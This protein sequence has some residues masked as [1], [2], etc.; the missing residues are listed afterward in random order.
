MAMD[1]FT[2]P[3]TSCDCERA[4]SSAR[5][6][7]T[8]D[9]NSLSASTIE[10]CQ[11]QKNWLRRKAVF[12]HLTQLTAFLKGEDEGPAITGNTI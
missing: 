10:A 2:I 11:L 3:A 12:S 9:R 8:C 6:T 7:I 4:F 5:R 1:Q